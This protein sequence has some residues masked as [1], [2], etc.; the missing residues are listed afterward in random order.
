MKFKIGDIVLQNKDWEFQRKFR[1]TRITTGMYPY[2]VLDLK[3][4]ERNAYKAEWL[5]NHYTLVKPLGHP[6]T[7]IFK[8]EI[9]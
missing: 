4:G 6:L 9:N 8:H 3:S 5:D 2:I 7:K 1:I